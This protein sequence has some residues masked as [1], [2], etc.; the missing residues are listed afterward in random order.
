MQTPLPTLVSA[1][2]N[3]TLEIARPQQRPTTPETSFSRTL[4]QNRRPEP[5]IESRESN[6]GPVVD[7]PART[8]EPDRRAAAP[9][10]GARNAE[11]PR[12]SGS[13]A[14]P[15]AQDAQESHDRAA[16][17]AADGRP[18]EPGA[19][20]DS[21]NSST[22]D[23]A[24]SQA[25]AEAVVAARQAA[26]G[27]ALGSGLEGSVENQQA[28][29]QQPTAPAAT[30]PEAAAP[31][32]PAGPGL[33]FDTSLSTGATTAPVQAPAQP[34]TA[35]NAGGEHSRHDA[36]TGSGST[37]DGGQP[38]KAS[39]GLESGKGFQGTAEQ[40]PT[41]NP[42]LGRA[43]QVQSAVSVENITGHAPIAPSMTAT[44]T[45][46]TVTATGAAGQTPAPPNA[47]TQDQ[48]SQLVNRV[49]RGL[50]A[51]VN[52]RGGALN[53]RLQ[54][55]ELGQLRVQMTIARGVVTAQFQP[56]SAEVQAILDRSLATLRAALESHGLTVERLSVQ[57]VQPQAGGQAARDTADEQTHQQRNQHDAGE[58]QSRGRRDGQGETAPRRF[59]FQTDY[60]FEMPEPVATPAGADES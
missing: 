5:E 43:A 52:Q 35:A 55:P 57:G 24:M 38:V 32:A 20:N 16:S 50:S 18:V 45:S 2:G 9:D 34:D 33:Q 26:S 7:T 25:A 40:E 17:G 29:V 58:G 30:P 14:Q 48:P 53:M 46:A 49:V 15:T 22:A 41:G 56:A 3:L 13:T 59:A 47:Q 27:I 37:A 51:M 21:Q 54:P 44:G 60:E 39:T 8:P 28:D 36:R 11:T 42:A 31:Q 6:P 12:R 1:A 23:Q 4:S 19:S 10:D